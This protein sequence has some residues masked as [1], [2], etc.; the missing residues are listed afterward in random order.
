MYIAKVLQPDTTSHL[1]LVTQ[2]FNI[3]KH[4]TIKLQFMPF[5]SA[6]EKLVFFKIYLLKRNQLAAFIFKKQQGSNKEQ[7]HLPW[8]KHISQETLEE[9]KTNQSCWIFIYIFC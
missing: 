8:N 7:E 1:Q 3:Q 4:S 5:Q 2:E 6:D 9:W